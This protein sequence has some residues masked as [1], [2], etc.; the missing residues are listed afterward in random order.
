M[1]GWTHYVE[2]P[3]DFSNLWVIRFDAAGD[4]VEFTEWWMEHDQQVAATN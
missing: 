2:P 3:S 4:C 1:R